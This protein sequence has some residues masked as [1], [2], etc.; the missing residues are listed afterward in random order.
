MHLE[1]FHVKTINLLSFLEGNS[2]VQYVVRQ[3]HIPNASFYLVQGVNIYFAWMFQKMYYDLVSLRNIMDALLC[4]YILQRRNATSTNKNSMH[5]FNFKFPIN[6]IYASSI[7]SLRQWR[8]HLC[9]AGKR[10]NSAEAYEVW[11]IV[12]LFDDPVTILVDKNPIAIIAS[13]GSRVGNE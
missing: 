10:L 13:M 1:I 5:F 3:F 8:I 7:L 12:I 11:S 4:Y 9:S 2:K 6:T